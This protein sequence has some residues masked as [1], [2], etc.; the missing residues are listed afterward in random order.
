M[1]V[2]V[3]VCSFYYS[4]LCCGI[5]FCPIPTP[6]TPY[7]HTYPNTAAYTLHPSLYTDAVCPN[8]SM[9][10]S[11]HN[12]TP[13]QGLAN[14]L[15][16]LTREFCPSL[17]EGQGPQN[18]SE[19]DSW[20]DTVSMIL[21]GDRSS[22][23]E[24]TSVARK[25]NSRLGGNGYLVGEQLS[26]ADLYCYWAVCGQGAVKLTKNISDWLYRVY[27]AV[28]ALGTFPCKCVH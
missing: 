12:Q 15:R 2:C 17:Y 1:C 14:I 26:L 16:F 18:A 23:K 28:P 22:T 25:L 10:V 5:L 21:L 6:H 20:V 24:K 3:C 4:Y 19:I 27:A 8:V 9:M 7:T 11:P 13:V